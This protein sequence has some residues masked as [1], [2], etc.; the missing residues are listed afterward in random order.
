VRVT[1][2]GE[3][4]DGIDG[5]R[6]GTPLLEHTGNPSGWGFFVGACPDL[7]KQPVH[8]A[9]ESFRLQRLLQV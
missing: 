3:N 8:V 6:Y 7:M 4:K 2:A 5:H 9:D 1:V